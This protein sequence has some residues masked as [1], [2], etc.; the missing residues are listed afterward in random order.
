MRLF[1]ELIHMM[2]RPAIRQF[3]NSPL[4]RAATNIGAANRK[5]R[6]HRVL[7]TITD[8]ASCWNV[9]VSGGEWFLWPTVCLALLSLSVVG[10]ALS[11]AD[12]LS[13]NEEAFVAA[14]ESI[15]IEDLK[16]HVGTLASDALQ[17]REA[18]TTS[19]HAAS[20]YLVQELRKRRV[21]PAAPDGQFI[22]EFNGSM[23]N[24]LACVKG[25]DPSIADEV[26]IVCAHYDHVGFGTP[27]NSRGPIGY[28]HNG[29]DD[30]ASGTAALL[31][32]I[33]AMHSLPQ[34][35]RRTVLF[36]FWDGEE[37]GLLGSKHWV[38]SPTVPLSRVKLVINSDMIGR[39]RPEGI[40]V[41][42]SR[43]ARG[44]RRLVS[45]SNS[46]AV[47]GGERL[48]SVTP[49]R[50]DSVS[51]KTTVQG[52]SATITNSPEWKLA[53]K[54]PLDF[55]WQIRADSDH[56]PFIA[57]NVPALMLHTG[58][59]DDYHRPSDDADKLN[60]EGIQRVSRLMLLI[61]MRAA[62]ANDLPSF[63]PEVHQETEVLQKQIEQP[64]VAPPSRLGIA[65]KIDL[66]KQRIVEV[67][68]VAPKSP[69]DE[70]GLKAGDR[71]LAFGGHTVSDFEDFRTLVMTAPTP[72]TAV[73]QRLGEAG[74]RE[75]SV[76]M[77]GEPTRLGILWRTDEAEPNCL[78]LTQVLHCSPADLAGLKPHD[79]ILRIGG[80]PVSTGESF[81]Q[82]VQSL[83][84]PIAVNY[85]RSGVIDSTA[86]D[87]IPVR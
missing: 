67:T 75:L 48:T 19:G 27:R 44:L 34:P 37:K 39:L 31:E 47:L 18:G 55:T 66:A 51:D 81:R 45:Q 20:A 40:E 42:G 62:E 21:T 6:V 60:Y 16:T 46:S 63:R 78:I 80:Q 13:I 84:G 29:A 11:R 68:D 36:A 83:S 76:K 54:A 5:H 53:P 9:D 74:P 87:V 33:D 30:N 26:V 70:A 17:G 23:R 58:K 59:H 32:V 69:A 86:I 15:R 85:E 49:A 14:V 7:P 3:C 4:Q 79:R 35:P 10:T 25:R 56:H 52:I 43:V 73:V 8:A 41:T 72:V 65:W 77:I 24:V 38:S 61:A 2:R 22:Q 50:A 64:P 28:I 1:S 12:E 57:A 82:Q 71:V